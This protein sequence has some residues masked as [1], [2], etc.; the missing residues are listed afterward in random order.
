MHLLQYDNTSELSQMAL[1]GKWM[2]STLDSHSSTMASKKKIVRTRLSVYLKVAA[3]GV[4][5]NLRS[6]FLEDER[7]P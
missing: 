7:L 5:I 1:G 3:L 2:I 4:T 6:G